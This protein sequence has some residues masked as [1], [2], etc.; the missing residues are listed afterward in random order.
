MRFYY[1]VERELNPDHFSILI[2]NVIEAPYSHA[3]I[4]VEDVPETERLIFGLPKT[5]NIIFEA[6]IPNYCFRAEDSLDPKVEQVM[7]KAEIKVRN[8]SMALGWLLGNMGK[9]YS[10]SQSIGFLDLKLNTSFI[11]IWG[12]GEGKGV[13]SEFCARFGAVHSVRP[14]FFS[15]VNL[16]YVNPK[17]GLKLF[18]E[19]LELTN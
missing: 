9:E 8:E 5:G 13:C 2:M 7:H 17:S 10:L 6:T 19:L 18:K 4:L 1:C 15:E 3:F 14:D 16:E 12:N 11:K